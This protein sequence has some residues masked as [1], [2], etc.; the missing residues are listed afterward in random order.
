VAATTRRA[1]TQPAVPEWVRELYVRIDTQ[2]V[3]SYIAEFA[4]DADLHFGSAPVVHGAEAIRAAIKKADAGHQMHHTIVNCWEVGDT[5]ILE[6]D[7]D[8]RFEDGTEVVFPAITVL[9]RTDG[10]IT[11]M[12]VYPVPLPQN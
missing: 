1:A 7:V 10:A 5:T 9:E 8:Y 6:F 12:R 11:S 3:D 2:G 4:D